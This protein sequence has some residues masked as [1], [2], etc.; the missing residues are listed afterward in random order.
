[1]SGYL[2]YAR[3]LTADQWQDELVSDFI[4]QAVERVR[5]TFWQREPMSSIGQRLCL[6]LPGDFDMA[7]PILEN[8]SVDELRCSLFIS[9]QYGAF[10][11]P[12]SAHLR[13]STAAEEPVET[14]VDLESDYYL[15]D[16]SVMLHIDDEL[17]V[18][19]EITDVCAQT[20]D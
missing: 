5:E 10:S 15:F 14:S 9:F 8:V 7:S 4:W 12:Y 18:C 19:T 17:H 2:A 3:A 13:N 1:M 20:P 11:K 6:E 16:V